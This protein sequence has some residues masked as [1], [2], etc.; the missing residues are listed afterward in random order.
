MQDMGNLPVQDAFQTATIQAVI[1]PV[2]QN[3]YVT[4]QITG[5]TVVNWP[6]M[7]GII[8]DQVRT[9]CNEAYNAT[10]IV[11]PIIS[12]G[13]SSF[14]VVCG[15]VKLA[16]LQGSSARQT[17]FIVTPIPLTKCEL[18]YSDQA[19]VGPQNTSTASSSC[20]T[21]F[22]QWM[23][24]NTGSNAN[25]IGGMLSRKDTQCVTSWELIEN[26]MIMK[27]SPIGPKAFD[28][29]DTE[30]VGDNTLNAYSGTAY[31]ESD[32][33]ICGGSGEHVTRIENL[34][35]RDPL[36]A[37]G[38]Q[39]YLITSS[40]AETTTMDLEYILHLEGIRTA[41]YTFNP[42]EGGSNSI[43]VPVGYTA[44]PIKGQRFDIAS[45]LNMIRSNVSTD[46]L[47]SVVSRGIS[48]V[49]GMGGGGNT[50]R[51]LRQLTNFGTT[52]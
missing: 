30:V 17:S 16:S 26:D 31:F 27:F 36:S 48:L 15:G 28:I 23:R 52:L 38:W 11:N 14:R 50:A 22:G 18:A 9:N 10:N 49:N 21:K 46:D 51:Q 41:S 40:G 37:E 8:A 35:S 20:G 32:T 44:P 25:N 43:Y 7:F 5:N 34:C 13:L 3:V 45:L 19:G 33:V 1:G 29:H 6:G 12:G 24:D 47:I 39:G 4:G 42:S 2:D